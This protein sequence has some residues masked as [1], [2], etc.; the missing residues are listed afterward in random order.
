MVLPDLKLI[1]IV[2]MNKSPRMKIYIAGPYSK[3]DII[4]NVQIAIHEGD[5]VSNLGHVPYIPHLTAFWHLVRQ[6]EYQFWLDYDMEWLRVCDALLR[7]PGESSGA[8]KEVIEAQR[9]GLIIYHSIFDIP[10]IA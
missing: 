9:L 3:G 10:R 1:K 5:Y 8:D 4:A 7:L 6:H 2:E